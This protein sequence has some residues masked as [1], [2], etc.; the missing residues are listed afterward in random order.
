MDK[1]TG[2]GVL[3]LAVVLVLASSGCASSRARSNQTAKKA[4][5]STAAGV[6]VPEGLLQCSKVYFETLSG[7][8]VVDCASQPIDRVCSYYKSGTGKSE[9]TNT[10]EYSNECAAC[11]YYGENGTRWTGSTAYV[12][13]GYAKGSCKKTTIKTGF[14]LSGT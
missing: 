8:Y 11:Q 6:E 12:H 10:R 2:F 5:N 7:K 4:V 14:S 9:K 1:R 3:L 13:L